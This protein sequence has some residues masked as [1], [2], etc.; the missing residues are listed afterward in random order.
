M[1]KQPSL[2]FEIL[3]WNIQQAVE[4]QLKELKYLQEDCPLSGSHFE[5]RQGFN[6]LAFELFFLAF[7]LYV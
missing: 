4:K 5:I 6:V 7:S 2:T 1:K 3:E